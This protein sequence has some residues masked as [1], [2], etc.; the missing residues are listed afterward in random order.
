MRDKRLLPVMLLV[1]VVAALMFSRA[2]L[3]IIS[4]CGILIFFSGSFISQRGRPIYRYVLVAIAMVLLIFGYLFFLEP[5]SSTLE[6]L[7]GYLVFPGVLLIAAF[8]CKEGPRFIPWIVVLC[9]LSIMPSVA[10]M[11]GNGSLAQA[12]GKGQVAYTLMERDHLRFSIWVSG[13]VGLACL[14]YLRRNDRR[15]LPALVVLAAFLVVFSVRTG[16]I[17]LLLLLVLLAIESALRFRY[18]G[19]IIIIAATVTVF[20]A[21]SYVPFVR[22]KL[23]Y[24]RWEWRQGGRAGSDDTRKTVNQLA[25][26]MIGEKPGGWGIEGAS[27]EL[28]RR[29][30]ETAP[31]YK[32]YGR[33]FN[34]Y[35][36]WWLS[37]GWF[38]GSVFVLLWM[39]TLAWLFFSRSY[40]TAVWHLFYAL[41]CLYESNLEMQYGWFLYF[42]FTGLFYN[43]EVFFNRVPPQNRVM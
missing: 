11:I 23:N 22:E 24:A 26:K 41:T 39:V 18:R 31:L 36:Q 7:A 15:L 34:Q 13:C 25:W 27:G 1:L 38:A 16:W 2:L 30:K 37:A 42:F 28:S 21:A 29:M 3:S 14:Y 19:L 4:A 6:R 43:A 33:P 5:R 8:I 17:Y 35:Y 10:D 40:F 9:V 12:Y 20:L 32:V